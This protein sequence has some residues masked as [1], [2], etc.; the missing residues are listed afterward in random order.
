MV[1]KTPLAV[2]FWAKVDKTTSPDGCWLWMGGKDKPWNDKMTSGYGRFSAHLKQVGAHRVSWELT[3]GPIPEGLEVLHHCDNPPCVR[4]AHLFLGTQS[5]NLFD[6]VKKGRACQAVGEE[7]PHKLTLIQ[8][9]EILSSSLI[10]QDIANKFG[11]ARQTISDIRLGKR[12]VKALKRGE[13][14]H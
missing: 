9:R 6:A 5:D 11:V 8:V 10:Q 3:N 1:V 7:R 4:P 12:W 13:N 14:V 2:R